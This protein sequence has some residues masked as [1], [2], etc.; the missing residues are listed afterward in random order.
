MLNTLNIRA[1][2]LAATLALAGAAGAQELTVT[3]SSGP[4]PFTVEWEVPNGTA[5]QA[6]G[7]WSG[8]KAASGTEQVSPAVGN[9][10]ITLSCTVPGP[11]P[12]GW[13][14]L[15]WTHPTSN[16]DGTPYTDPKGYQILAERANPPTKVIAQPAATVTQYRVEGLGDG[17]WYFAVR[18]KNL[19]DRVGPLS[20]V[21]NKTI[22]GSPA[23]V[24]WSATNA[25]TVTEREPARPQAPVLSVE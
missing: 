21:K 14:K 7:A 2:A 12:T 6:A 16:T 5:C 1:L 24:S 25:I 4:G 22:T 11:A 9:R 23:T 15:T 19:A 20:E 8:A 18:S 13:A 17:R 3:P 10:N